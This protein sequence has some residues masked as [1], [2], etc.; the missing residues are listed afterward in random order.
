MALTDIKVRTV[1]PLDKPFK[2]TAGDGMRLLINP[3]GSKYWRLKNRFGGKQKMLSEGVYPTVTLVEV[4][5]RREIAKKL[6]SDCIDPAEK[7]KEDKIK[8][9]GSPTFES[10]ARDWHA[11]CSKMIFVS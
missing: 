1:K 3:N 10:V 9:G 5:K 11:S 4:R 6:V 7:K 8:Q 2:L